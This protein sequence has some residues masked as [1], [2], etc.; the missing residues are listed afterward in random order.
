MSNSFLPLL[1]PLC[2]EDDISTEGVAMPCCNHSSCKSC[3]ATWFEREE[4][5][6]RATRPT[7]PFCRSSTCD[8]EVV[9]TLG[10][11]FRPRRASYKD[12]S[13]DDGISDDLT[14]QWLNENT[15]LCRV[16]GSHIEKE[17]GCDL[18][19]CLC[20]HRFCYR[21]GTPGGRLC[22]CSS[23]RHNFLNSHCIGHTPIRD[24]RGRVDLM[25]CIRRRKIQQELEARLEDK[26]KRTSVALS[27]AE[28]IVASVLFLS[29]LL[30]FYLPA[31]FVGKAFNGV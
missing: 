6:G 29:V 20:G 30:A 11:P 9:A 31:H 3:L 27:P 28:E 19:E 13:N 16:C 1:C 18:M 7:C 21:C 26:C 14:L 25:A 15:A 22:G 17:G 24:G 23:T 4:A 10:R 2:C 8:E 5:S 12:A